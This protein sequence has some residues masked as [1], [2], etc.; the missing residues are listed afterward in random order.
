L[1]PFAIDHDGRYCEGCEHLR[2]VGLKRTYAAGT[3]E[4]S[5]RRAI[6]RFKYG[7]KPHLAKAL[8]P[9]LARRLRGEFTGDAPETVV[10]V[11]L[12]PAR[13][14]D[15]TFDQAALLASHVARQLGIPLV[16]GAIRRVRD[17]PPLAHRNREQRSDAV[18][19]AFAVVAPD[20]IAGNRVLLVD[21][22]MTTG[23]TCSECALALKRAGAK[24]VSVAVLARTP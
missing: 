13:V 10:A 1:G 3:Y 12:H 21:D 14:R 5:L 24:E 6:C 20:L 11:P 4:G 19:G 7:R 16:N 17:T 8:G 23:A 9:I 22:V 18:K 15:R 2:L